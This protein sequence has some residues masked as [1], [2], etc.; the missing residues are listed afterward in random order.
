MTKLSPPSTS[1]MPANFGAGRT[2]IF[3]R[4]QCFSL[5]F[6]FFEQTF[7]RNKKAYIASEAKQEKL[8]RTALAKESASLF[9]EQGTKQ[10]EIDSRKVHN[11]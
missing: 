6:F 10:K 7:I 5:L 4:F 11:I 1:F 3:L 9:S 2:F 8:N